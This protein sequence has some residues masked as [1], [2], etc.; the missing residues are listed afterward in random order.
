MAL[1]LKPDCNVAQEPEQRFHRIHDP[2][3]TNINIADFRSS[4]VLLFFASFSLCAEHL[5]CHKLP[6]GGKCFQFYGIMESLDGKCRSFP[7]S[8]FDLCLIYSPF[9]IVQPQ[10]AT[11]SK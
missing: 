5:S 3:W 8:L 1:A 10:I 9:V 11:I 2:K 6:L 7:F 4:R